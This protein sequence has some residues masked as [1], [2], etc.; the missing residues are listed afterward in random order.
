MTLGSWRWFSIGVDAFAS[1]TACC[2][3]DLW[4]L[5]YII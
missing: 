4:P 1:S 2:D 3:L 5:T